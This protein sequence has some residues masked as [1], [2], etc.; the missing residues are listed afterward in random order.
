MVC[1]RCGY[2]RARRD[3]QTRL[4]GQRWRCLACGRRFTARSSSAF[5]GHCFPD[6]IIA[7]AVRYSV[8]SHLS[9]ADVVEWLAER[10]VAVDRSTNYRWVCRF[11]PPFAESARPHR[12]AVGAKW[13]VEE[14]YCRLN[15]TQMYCSRAIDEDGQVV[16]AD[17]SERRCSAAQA[18][19]ERAVGETGV[20]PARITTEKATCYPPA[21]HAVLPAAEHA[22][23]GTC[24]MGW[25]ATMAT[26][27]SGGRP[28]AA[29]SGW[30]PP[31]PSAAATPSSGTCAAALLT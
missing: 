13:R 1:I 16:D 29:L 30:P 21:W 17:C 14:T 15:G 18:F 7:I 10:G 11:L 24:I 20:T 23:R 2:D 9:Y 28:C 19:V 8:R 5:S 27:S 22:A 4:S 6:H 31:T 26:A 12:P 3:G 25:S